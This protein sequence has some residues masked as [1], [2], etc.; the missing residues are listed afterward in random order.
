MAAGLFAVE[1]FV[2]AGGG[3]AAAG[4]AVDH[5]DLHQV[6]LVHFFD[7]VFFFAEGGGE[8]ADADGTAA[9]FVVPC[10]GRRGGADRGGRACARTAMIGCTT[11]GAMIGCATGLWLRLKLA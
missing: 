1:I 8:G 4:G 7:G 3:Y 5:A 11:K 6:R 2:G 9:V 10:L